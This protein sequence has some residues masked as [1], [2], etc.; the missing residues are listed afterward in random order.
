MFSV[1]LFGIALWQLTMLTTR[2][3]RPAT[4]YGAKWYNQVAP[5]PLQSEI[6]GALCDAGVGVLI[7]MILYIISI[8]LV[9]LSIPDLYKGFAAS[10]SKKGGSQREKSNYFADAGKKLFGAVVISSLPTILATIGFSLLECVDAV[11]IF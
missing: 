5:A 4:F 11:Q 7:G 9:Y 2:Y 1:G 6:G 3:A 8:L 10:R